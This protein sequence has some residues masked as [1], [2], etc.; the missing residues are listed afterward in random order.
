MK[1]IVV[2]KCYGGFGLSHEAVLKYAEFKNWNLIIREKEKF[3]VPYEYFL[4]KETD[5]NYWYDGMIEDRADPELVKVV[6]TMG[7]KANGWAA[8][9]AIIEIPDDVDWEIG[10]YDGA[11]WVQEKH[12]RWY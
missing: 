3:S 11:E 10:E 6:E 4:D 8:D 7:E 12:R 1:R 9:L 5:E 2:N